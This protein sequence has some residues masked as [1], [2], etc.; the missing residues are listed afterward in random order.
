MYGVREHI[1]KE[2]YLIMIQREI[3]KGC[4]FKFGVEVGVG[5]SIESAP[6]LV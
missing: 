2:Y 6:P 4:F 3:C 5:E 1:L